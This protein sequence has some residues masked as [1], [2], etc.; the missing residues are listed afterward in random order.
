LPSEQ[1]Q[2]AVKIL[3]NSSKSPRK[4]AFSA[5]WRQNWAYNIVIMHKKYWWSLL[6]AENL[7]KNRKN[8]VFLKKSQKKACKC[9]FAVLL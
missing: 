1:L 8:R 2:E 7:N 5:L 3:Q 4:G 9:G 6:Q